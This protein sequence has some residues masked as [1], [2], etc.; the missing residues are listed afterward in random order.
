MKLFQITLFFLLSTVICQ[1]PTNFMKTLQNGV[2][3]TQGK[4]T[5]FMCRHTWRVFVSINKPLPPTHY[6]AQAILIRNQLNMAFNGKNPWTKKLITTYQHHI[7]IKRLNIA[8]KVIK[9]L[10][11]PFKFVERNSLEKRLIHKQVSKKTR[12]LHDS[13]PKSRSKRGLFN[14]IGKG[15]HSLFGLATSHDV[16]EVKSQLQFT[17]QQQTSVKHL[18]NNLTTVVNRVQ[19]DVQF[20]RRTI[21]GNIRNIDQIFKVFYNVSNTLNVI[22]LDLKRKDFLRIIDNSIQ[23]FTE[24]THAY[25]H[26]V[27]LY[28][29]RRNSLEAGHLSHDLMPLTYLQDIELSLNKTYFLISPYEWY[30]TFAPI[31]AL[32]LRGNLLYKVDLCVID[33]R[34]YL[35]Y[36]LDSFPCPIPNSNT[37]LYVKLESKHVTLDTTSGFFS[38]PTS[39]IGRNPRVCRAF[40]FLKPEIMSCVSSIILQKPFRDCAIEIT[41]RTETNTVLHEFTDQHF[42]V[43]THGELVRLFC[44]GIPPRYY[45][46]IAGCY[47]MNPGKCIV[48]SGTWRIESMAITTEYVTIVTELLKYTKLNVSDILN[49]T[50]LLHLNLTHEGI[51]QLKQTRTVHLE[52]LPI[53]ELSMGH[54]NDDLERLFQDILNYIV[55][56]LVLLWFTIWSIVN[57]RNIKHFLVKIKTCTCF[58]EVFQDISDLEKSEVAIIAQHNAYETSHTKTKPILRSRANSKPN[59]DI[60]LTKLD[61]NPTEHTSRKLIEVPMNIQ[62]R[63]FL[64]SLS[65]SSEVSD[66]SQF[67]VTA[68]SHEI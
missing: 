51:R 37:T 33:H 6:N 15:L 2:L 65:I 39:C 29:R 14:F 43:C 25:R 38:N 61:I 36:A 22:L 40:I 30:Y 59:N 47:I 62:Q 20:N 50:Q 28:S 60:H 7:R 31:I 54:L 45:D 21:N 11:S 68:D 12:K 41:Q 53:L 63:T 27:E 66:I 32:E 55:N 57:R 4:E 5:I 64:D 10:N 18:L 8:L 13:E 17:F 35:E 46:I 49:V 9:E 48:Q 3:V 34:Q 24:I 52:Q 1:L 44:D 19:K 23:D 26:Q 42:I 16:D 67:V 56:T 58:T